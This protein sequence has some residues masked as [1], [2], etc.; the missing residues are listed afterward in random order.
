MYNI[1]LYNI[2]KNIENL[3]IVFVSTAVFCGKSIYRGNYRKGVILCCVWCM[4]EP[5]PGKALLSMK[6]YANV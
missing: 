2:T 3:Y 4:E 5:E 1:M 6:K